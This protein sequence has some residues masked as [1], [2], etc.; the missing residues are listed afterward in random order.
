M[1]YNGLYGCMIITPGNLNGN[2]RGFSIDR[3]IHMYNLIVEH[4]CRVQKCEL[5]DSTGTR[6]FTNNYEKG[7]TH[8]CEDQS[9]QTTF[10]LFNHKVH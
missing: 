2:S 4:E 7:D 3:V 9:S 10:Y 6:A 5:A 1:I 8:Q